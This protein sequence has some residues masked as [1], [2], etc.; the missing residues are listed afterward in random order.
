MGTYRLAH[1]DGETEPRRTSRMAQGHTRSH[2]RRSS[3]QPHRRAASLELPEL[4]KLK[5]GCSA[6]TAYRECRRAGRSFPLNR[7][8]NSNSCRS[9]D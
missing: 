8:L 2:R 1:R 6:R 9:A 4:V 5:S 3:K 7:A